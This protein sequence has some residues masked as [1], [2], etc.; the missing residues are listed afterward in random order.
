MI[1][2]NDYVCLSC[3]VSGDG[4]TATTRQ[5][6]WID[7]YF[8]YSIAGS[9]ITTLDSSSRKKI[10]KLHPD[11][12]DNL[13][14]SLFFLFCLCL[15]YGVNRKECMEHQ[16][17][18]CGVLVEIANKRQ[19]RK[20][21]VCLWHSRIQGEQETPISTNKN[22]HTVQENGKN[23]RWQR[24]KKN[25][26]RPTRIFEQNANF[27]TRKIYHKISGHKLTCY[28]LHI[29]HVTNYIGRPRKK[30]ASNTIDAPKK[31]L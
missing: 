19:M 20:I 11:E 13:V 7:L 26:N 27:L 5:S 21:S 28:R 22:G 18:L 9:R 2:C 3:S 31:K 10:N 16:E 4:G 8:M 30:R 29:W 6:Q 14:T 25:K 15:W 17:Q 1:Y 12:S 24:M 23:E